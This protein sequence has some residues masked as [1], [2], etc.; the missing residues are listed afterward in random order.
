M[1]KIR[2]RKQIEL[3]TNVTVL[4]KKAAQAMFEQFDENLVAVERRIPELTL[5]RPIYT[6]FAIGGIQKVRS[7]RGG[8]GVDQKR[9][10]TNR[11]VT[12]RQ[13]RANVLFECP[14]IRFIQNLNGTMMLLRKTIQI[15]FAVHR[16]RFVSLSNRNRRL[17]Y[18]H[19]NS[20]RSF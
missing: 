5:I 8:R 12:N 3:V 17:V 14:H 9:I 15:A 6:G 11:G 18:R 2:N 19:D 13:I 16:Y 4:K 20:K 1:G 7:P 10:K